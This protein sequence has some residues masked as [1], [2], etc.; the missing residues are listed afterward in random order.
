VDRIPFAH[1]EAKKRFAYNCFDAGGAA[2]VRNCCLLIVLALRF[3]LRDD[4]RALP[5]PLNFCSRRVAMLDTRRQLLC[6]AV[7][8]AAVLSFSTRLFGQHPSPQPIP[9]PNAPNPNFPQGM[10]GPGPTAPDQ[11]TIDKQNQAQIR[12]D[13]DKMYS[14]VTEMKQELGVTNTTTV[15]SVNF[16]K[17]AHEVEKLAKQVKELAKG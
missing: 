3:A 2:I 12:A 6:S 1:T 13:V 16:V 14:M 9:S 5:A 7:S 4:K 10:N 15:L 17:K 8:I 11:K